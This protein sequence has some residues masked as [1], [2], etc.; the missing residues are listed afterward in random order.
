MVRYKEKDMEKTVRK[1]ILGLLSDAEAP[2]PSCVIL[3]NCEPCMKNI[4]KCCKA[5]CNVSNNI[6]LS[7]IHITLCFLGISLVFL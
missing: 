3:M 1:R 6:F 5:F 2:L 4:I 7:Q